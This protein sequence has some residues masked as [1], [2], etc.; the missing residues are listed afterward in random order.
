MVRSRGDTQLPQ[1]PFFSLLLLIFTSAFSL[2]LKML[3]SLCCAPCLASQRLCG[4]MDGTSS[5]I[6]ETHK[7]WTELCALAHLLVCGVKYAWG[8][9]RLHPLGVEEWLCFRTC[10]QQFQGKKAAMTNNKTQPQYTA[11]WLGRPAVRASTQ[12]CYEIIGPR[13][14]STKNQ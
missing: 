8:L 10:E 2:M 7:H 6:W 4:Y 9:D 12:S 14:W 1:K 11:Y 13:V 5:T 3:Q